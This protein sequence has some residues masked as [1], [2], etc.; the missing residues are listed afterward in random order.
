MD[1]QCPSM[2]LPLNIAFSLSHLLTCSHNPRVRSP[3]FQKVVPQPSRGE[4]KG[5]G[6][7]WRDNEG[8]IGKPGVVDPAFGAHVDAQGQ[9]IH[10]SLVKGE[11]RDAIDSDV[12]EGEETKLDQIVDISLKSRPNA[13]YHQSWHAQ[14][15]S[16]KTNN[17]VHCVQPICTSK[18]CLIT[19]LNFRF[20]VNFFHGVFFFLSD[21]S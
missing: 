13:P 14:H 4:D 8:D 20:S 15:A 10:Q 17:Y 1:Q 16:L 3:G 7:E 11:H 5:N 18:C 19:S 9:E 2:G 21:G 12:E 6:G